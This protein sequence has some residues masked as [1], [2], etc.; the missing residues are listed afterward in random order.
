MAT[1]GSASALRVAASLAERLSDGAYFV[2]LDTLR[3][4]DLLAAAI[5]AAMGLKS[6][7]EGPLPALK[8]HLGEREV[9]LVLDNFEQIASAADVVDELLQAAPRLRVLATSRAPLGLYG[10]S[11]Y[12]V[13]P[14][15]L[16]DQA[17]L[18]LLEDLLAVESVAL[19]ASRA[20]AVKP[21]LPHR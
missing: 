10:E 2:A 5:A 6:G 19:F 8:S 21:A 18:P 20:R 1:I 11:E 7:E 17:R 15:D 9:L 3:E 14:L 12:P 16:P 4:P 13:P